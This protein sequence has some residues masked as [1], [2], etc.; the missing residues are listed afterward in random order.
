MRQ[1]T[2]LWC[3]RSERLWGAAD[4]NNMKMGGGVC[5][6]T[7]QQQEK[8]SKEEIV[9]HL[10]M[11]FAW[12]VSELCGVIRWGVYSTVPKSAAGM[13]YLRP[14]STLRDD[15]HQMARVECASQRTIVPSSAAIWRK[16]SRCSVEYLKMN[17]FAR[18]EMLWTLFPKNHSQCFSVRFHFELKPSKSIRS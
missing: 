10:P 5:I 3:P 16:R 11:V 18:S 15:R 8:E 13:I 4:E 2:T 17:I 12:R 14:R 6:L 9:L 7:P 1:W